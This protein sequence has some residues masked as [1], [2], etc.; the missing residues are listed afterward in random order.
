VITGSE[1]IM[2]HN[3]SPEPLSEIRLRLDHNIYRPTV[4]QGLSVPAETTEGMV[5]TKFVI[6]GQVADLN[7]PP[8]GRGGGRGGQQPSLSAPNGDGPDERPNLPGVADSTEV[9][10]EARNRLENKAS[11]RA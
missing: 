9:A 3:E 2:L 8:P 1:T 7:A 5:V 4:P 6:D 11:R 10:C